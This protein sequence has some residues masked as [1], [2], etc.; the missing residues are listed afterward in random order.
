MPPNIVT[1]DRSAVRLRVVYWL[2]RL[3]LKDP[4]DL[5]VGYVMDDAHEGHTIGWTA[6]F[7]WPNKM[8]D[9]AGQPPVG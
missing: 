3:Q 8:A 1:M 4:A 2:A 9:A 6:D 5:W 7:Y